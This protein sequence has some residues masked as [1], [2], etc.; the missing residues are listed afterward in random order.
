MI[1][2]LLKGLSSGLVVKNSLGTL[3]RFHFLPVK[4]I[5]IK[6]VE[7]FVEASGKVEGPIGCGGCRG[8]GRVVAVAGK[9]SLVEV[10]EVADSNEPGPES[11]PILCVR[12]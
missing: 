2:L 11:V 12:T 8:G 4:Q 10:A 1:Y 3:S 9:D 5:L 7:L 6:V